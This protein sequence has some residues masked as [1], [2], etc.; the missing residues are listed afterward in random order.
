ML[1]VNTRCLGQRM[2]LLPW[3][4]FTWTEEH[5]QKFSTAEE[6]TSESP[7]IRSSMLYAGPC[8]F[9]SIYLAQ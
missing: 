2:V 6:V 7:G 3:C 8:P 1:L 5:S 4:F 9:H